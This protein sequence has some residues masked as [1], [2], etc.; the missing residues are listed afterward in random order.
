MNCYVCRARVSDDQRFCEQCGQPMPWARPADDVLADFDLDRFNE[1]RDEKAR[2]EDALEAIVTDAGDAGVTTADRGAWA[3]LYERWLFVRDAITDEM[4][5]FN[6]RI[7]DERRIGGD[8]R[9]KRRARVGDR[10]EGVDRR[11][12]YRIRNPFRKRSADP[13]ELEDRV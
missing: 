8:R 7:D 13:G 10:R 11:N 4:D 3:E 12:P 2:L 5:R 1:L 9:R 6:P